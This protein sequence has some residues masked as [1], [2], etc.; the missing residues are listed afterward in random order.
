VYEGLNRNVAS[1]LVAGV[2]HGSP[3]R[4]VGR[5]KQAENYGLLNY[6][7]FKELF[8]LAITLESKARSMGTENV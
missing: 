2:K 6:Q 3:E 4:I 8:T 5:E 7:C 1:R